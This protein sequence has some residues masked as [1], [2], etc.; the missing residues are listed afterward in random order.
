MLLE[1]SDPLQ[2]LADGLA[3]ARAGTGRLVLVGGEAGVGKTSLVREFC[4]QA[5]SVRVLHGACDALF[6]PSPL[7]PLLDVADEVGGGLAEL[8]AEEARPH[9]VAA[10]L[11]RELRD[12]K[13]T[14]LVLEDV[15][16]ADEA[17][18]DVLRLLGRRVE[19][20]PVVLVATYRD[21]ELD[22]AHPLRITLGELATGAAVER[23]RIEPLSPQAVG[24]LAEAHGFDSEEL[25]RKTGGNPFFVTEVLAS[26]ETE[27]PPTVRD[28]VIARAAR[29][30]PEA[31]SLLEAAAVA[32]PRLEL[33]LLA[34]LADGETG[35]LDE[36]LAS[37][38]LQPERDGLRFRHELARLALEE[39]VPP[40]RKLA[41]HR[42]AVLTLAQPPSGA[43][44]LARLAHHAEAAGDGDAV[45]RHAPRAGDLAASLGA[46]REAAAQ[47]ARALRFSDAQPLEL[48]AELL[49]RRSYECYLTDQVE[50]AVA[51]R[52]KA[53][54]CYRATG[55][56]RREGDSL[57]WLS[58]LLWFLGRN[59]EAERAAQDAVSL[60]E[61]LPPGTELAMA[62]SNVAQLRMLADMSEEAVVWGTRAIE[63]AERLGDV[64]IQAHALNNVG[65]AELKIAGDR[66]VEKLERSLE[67]ARAAGLEEHVA[68][69][70]CNL[71]AEGVQLRSYGLANR[72]L[73]EGIDYAAEHDL[74]SWRLYL[75]AWRA[76]SELDQG[77]WDDAVE[78]A[79]EVMRNPRT[80]PITKIPALVTLGLVRVRRGDPDSSSPLS[81]ALDIALSTGE[82]QRL[83]P[84][85]AARAESALLEGKP[86]AV[87]EATEDTLR[88]AVQR[89]APWAIGELA[90]LR[91]RAGIVEELPAAAV[92][93]YALQIAGHRRRAAEMWREIGCPYEAAIALGQSEAEDDLR[94][95]LDELRRLGARP[96]ADQVARRLRE[97]GAR[98]VPRGPRAGTSGN[99]AGLTARE[100]E[101]VGLVS[102]GMTNAEIA[103]RLFLSEK[104]VGHHV[105]AI[106]RKLGARTRGEASA[107]AARLGIASQDR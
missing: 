27:V 21:D 62:Y 22:L 48:K 5:R 23:L 50:D 101:V 107:E 6:T 91:W 89:Q 69:A 36:C 73:V 12:G 96:A 20:V 54:E 82:L 103:G 33:W 71:A 92:E 8:V 46:H 59:E 84:V 64:E 55:D 77:H 18:L 3:A 74:D 60:L 24:K 98:G 38:M 93:P 1:R 17:T 52:R 35:A 28:A 57:R 68:R 105:S 43:P 90:Y 42:K 66:G 34:A 47:F 41:L 65:T 39:L 4:S 11:V 61:R 19:G 95:S 16:W 72:Y 10:E 49:E 99:P 30:T 102:E 78:S 13:P 29:L 37:G 75:L 15:H 106:L 80:A 63:L 97:R 58:R 76:R 85:A 87:A 104:T 45:L 67:L 100:L 32:T 94:R 9:A 79:V 88:L 40:D 81:D 70:C 7:G 31:R 14:I 26:G 53:L 83:W 2:A 25:Y 56:R 86:E 44:D 51:A